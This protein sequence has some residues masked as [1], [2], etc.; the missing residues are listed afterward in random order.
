MATLFNYFWAHGKA[1]HQGKSTWQ[2]KA[3]SQDAR[4]RGKNESGTGYILHGHSFNDFLPPT[5]SHLLT[6]P[7]L[8][9]SS[10]DYYINEHSH[11]PITSQ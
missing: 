1:V 8:M 9:N 10:M 7:L 6:D 4:M 3:G 2:R 5:V 11:D